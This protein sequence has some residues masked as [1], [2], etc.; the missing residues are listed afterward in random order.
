[1]PARSTERSGFISV[2]MGFMKPDTRRSSP[3]V[4]PPS[5]PPALFVGR[6]TPIG[7]FVRLGRRDDFVVHLRPG[8]RCG[9]RSDADA[10]ALDRRNRH[11]RLRK[12]AVELAI[13]VHVAAEADR[14]AARD[15]LEGAAGGVAGVAAAIDLRNHADFRVEVGAAQRRVGADVARR[16]ERDAQRRVEADAVDAIHVAHDL[17]VERSEQLPGDG[18]CRDARRGLARARALEHIANVGAVVLDGARQIGVP[19][20]R[21]RH[22]RPDRSGGACR[23]LILGMHRLLPVLPVLVADQQRDRRAQRFA[24]S[25]ARQNLGLVGFDR[26][27]AAAAVPALAPLAAV[28]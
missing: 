28:R 20:T 2:A 24:R 21:P 13:P 14:Q 15:H 17:D 16:F 27:A 6:A 10:D 26:H 12:A 9:L 19:G 5:R 25:H 18:A 4:T 11:H 23:R 8:H 22:D 3:L 1:M 7:G